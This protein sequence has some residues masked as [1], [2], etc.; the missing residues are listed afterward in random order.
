M[1]LERILLIYIL[2]YRLSL[3]PTEQSLCQGRDPCVLIY[4]SPDRQVKVFP[5]CY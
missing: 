5:D 1:S 2:V 3:P 4:S